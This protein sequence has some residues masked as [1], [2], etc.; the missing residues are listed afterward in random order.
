MS[1]PWLS[2]LMPV[3]NGAATL[4]ATLASVVDQAEGIEFILVDQ[5]SVDASLEI[6]EGYRARMDLRVISAP[7][8]RNW[9]QNTNLA[10]GTARALRATLLHQDDLWRHGRAGTARSCFSR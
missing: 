9:V 7:D 2:V 6:A 3:Y 5:G 1:A 4:N 10:L 8:N